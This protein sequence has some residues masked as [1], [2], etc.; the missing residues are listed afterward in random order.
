MS[1]PKGRGLGGSTLINF[2][3]SIRGHRLDYD[4]W[5]AAGNPGWGYKDV[6]PYFMKL[7]DSSVEVRVFQ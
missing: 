6:L 5:E 1:W 2:M 3:I 7:E 4:K